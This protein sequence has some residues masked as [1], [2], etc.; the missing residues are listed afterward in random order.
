LKF[1]R[2]RFV[3]IGLITLTVGLLLLFPARVAYQWFAPPG[4]ALSGIDGT[5]WRGMAREGDVGGLYLRNVGWR[6]QPLKLFTGKIGY[7]VEADA[8]SGFVDGGVAIGLGGSAE[9]T[10][11][12]AS[13]SL[14]SLQQK[15][16]MPGLDGTVNLQFERLVF[17][18]G[19][20][21]AADGNLQVANLRAPLVHRSS[22]GGFRA[23]FFTQ[24]SGIMAS[25]EDTDAVLDL[26][27]SLSLS[28][29]RTYQFLAQ[30]APNAN[31]P[32]DLRE[33]MRFLGT[34]NERGQYE[35]RLEGQL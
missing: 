32:P 30:V 35:L 29:D 24:E 12:T 4:I 8:A 9:L 14:Q 34:P 6:V 19:I 1:S 10:G 17:E 26:A 15:V 27:G 22:I 11:L 7:A 13:L 31:T 28:P 25:V 5:I 2:F 18:N 16:G 33:Q 20:P 23:D 3:I 21:V